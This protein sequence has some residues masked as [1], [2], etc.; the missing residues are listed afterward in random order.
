[1]N[2]NPLSLTVVFLLVQ[3]SIPLP[4]NMGMSVESLFRCLDRM[5][6]LLTLPSQER[7]P[8]FLLVSRAMTKAPVQIRLLHST[9][10]ASRVEIVTR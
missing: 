6:C 4:I 2:D 7:F 8:K 1:M 3:L 5:V 10:M 9:I